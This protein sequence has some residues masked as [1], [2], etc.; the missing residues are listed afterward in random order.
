M[1]GL[2]SQLYFLINTGKGISNPTLCDVLRIILSSPWGQSGRVMDQGLVFMKAVFT[3]RFYITKTVLL[4]WWI[5][6]F[7]HV[8]MKNVILKWFW[9][10]PRF[11][12][13][14]SNSQIGSCT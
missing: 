5:L 1:S 2:K 11:P 14:P 7:N 4:S 12:S 3:Q 10:G 9:I 6:F 13:V 8:Q